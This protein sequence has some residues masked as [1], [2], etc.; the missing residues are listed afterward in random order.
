MT[1]WTAIRGQLHH[2]RAAHATRRQL[3]RELFCYNNPSDLNDLH[4]IVDRYPNHDTVGMRRI[5]A[6]RHTL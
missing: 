1:T 5:L 6:R 3:E 2:A 4:A